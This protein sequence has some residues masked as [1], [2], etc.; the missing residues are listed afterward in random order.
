L[1]D[2]LERYGFPAGDFFLPL[3]LGFLAFF[4][5]MDPFASF[6]QAATC[7]YYAEIPTTVNRRLFHLTNTEQ[8]VLFRQR[9]KKN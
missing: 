5:A 6:P 3:A 2:R 7:R 9:K 4:L 8:S 1:R